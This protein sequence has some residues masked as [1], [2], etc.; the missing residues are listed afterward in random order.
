MLGRTEQMAS[1]CAAACS[2]PPEFHR[3]GILAH[4]I[5]ATT[6]D[7]APTRKADTA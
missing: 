2:R 4:A 7:V 5:F 1:T 6:P 3:F